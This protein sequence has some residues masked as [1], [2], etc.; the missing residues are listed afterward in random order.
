MNERRYHQPADESS[1]EE[2]CLV[3]LR[4][5]WKMPGLARFGHRGEEQHGVD[6]LDLGGTHSGVR[7]SRV[8]PERADP[9]S[10]SQRASTMPALCELPVSSRNV[11]PRRP[12][13]LRQLP[14]SVP[15]V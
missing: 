6:L 10:T 14:A 8:V 1:F 7:P 12:R 13:G 3:L 2:F 15:R 5:H 11:P 4:D 9:M